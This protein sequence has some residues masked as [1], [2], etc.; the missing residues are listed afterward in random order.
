MGIKGFTGLLKATAPNAAKSIG[1]ESLRNKAVAIDAVLFARQFL[2]SLKELDS[3]ETRV[4]ARFNVLVNVLRLNRITPVFCFD[5]KMRI[6]QKEREARKRSLVR[7]RAVCF[8]SLEAERLDTLGQLEALIAKSSSIPSDAA[9]EVQSS[10]NAQSSGIIESADEAVVVAA[11]ITEDVSELLEPTPSQEAATTKPTPPT[12]EQARKKQ[13]LKILEES[14]FLRPLTPT[15]MKLRKSLLTLVANETLDVLPPAGSGNESIIAQEDSTI[16]NLD[17]SA[18]TKGLQESPT[19]SS[20]ASTTDS[21][22]LDE[23]TLIWSKSTDIGNSPDEIPTLNETNECESEY[24]DQYL[25]LVEKIST[26]ASLDDSS[27]V[28]GSTRLQDSSNN[29]SM[30]TQLNQPCPPYADA[31][32]QLHEE[33]VPLPESNHSIQESIPE[34]ILTADTQLSFIHLP[35]DVQKGEG[36]VE[37]EEDLSQL[38]KRLETKLTEQHNIAKDLKMRGVGIEMFEKSSELVQSLKSPPPPPQQSPEFTTESQISEFATI[39]AFSNIKSLIS[40]SVARHESL[41]TRTLVL[42][43]DCLRAIRKFLEEQHVPVVDSPHE[44]EALCAYLTATERTYASATEDMDAC[45]FGEGLV[46]RHLGRAVLNHQ[47]KLDA[48]LAVGALPFDGEGSG[49]CETLTGDSSIIHDGGGGMESDDEFAVSAAPPTATQSDLVQINPLEFRQSLGLTREQYVD[50]M[51]LCGTDF[52]ST[53]KQVG[54]K[55]ALKIIKKHGSIEE[56]LAQGKYEPNEGFDY[57][58]A[59]RMFCEALKEMEGVVDLEELDEAILHYQSKNQ[60]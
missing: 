37:K 49:S 23:S 32:A 60:E 55:T 27:V 25:H 51:I 34:P 41:T 10:M 9:A 36:S 6:K 44:G 14:D 3:I 1:L 16:D 19:I 56:I 47:R 31:Y 48:I 11:E 35:A 30:P 4:V 17:E 26:R 21:I 53:L 7:D 2:H 5:S 42:T 24:D 22:N 43:S 58:G 13:T 45:V 29:I 50:L 18:I 33:I 39:A 28:D 40:E 38:L 52:S 46:I 8:L 20:D 12:D 59:R 57:I 15:S 54:K